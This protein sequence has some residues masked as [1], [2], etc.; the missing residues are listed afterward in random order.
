M[1]TFSPDSTSSHAARLGAADSSP[2]GATSG[3]PLKQRLKFLFGVFEDTGT[4]FSDIEGFRLGAAFSYYATFSIF[5]LMLLTVTIIG[6]VIGDD[7]PARERMLSAV[8]TPDSSV[9]GVLE[10]TL[11]AMQTN[12]S[13]RGLSAIIGLGTLL[14]SASGAMVELYASLNKIWRVPVPKT[15]GALAAVKA[16]V[17]E[18]LSG[19]ALVL[20]IGLSMLASLFLSSLVT[21][22]QNTSPIK[23]GPWLMRLAEQG[24]SIVFIGLVIAAAFHFVPR[25][26]PKWKDVFA[27]AMLTSLLLSLL[28]AVFATYLGHLAN[29][30]AY[31]IVG[32]VLALATWI[33]LSSQIMF[34]GATFTCTLC[35]SRGHCTVDRPEAKADVD[36]TADA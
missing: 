17:S 11:T 5:P 7:A 14:F 29:Y 16:F 1:N 13:A 30:S 2:E 36:A 32:G 3:A 9:Y 26:H 33:Y 20:G 18:R 6:F 28:R 21:A 10:Q 34:L 19:F 24:I 15:K 12:R 8:A 22:I 35:E 4:R 27:G 25:T 23:V 31:G